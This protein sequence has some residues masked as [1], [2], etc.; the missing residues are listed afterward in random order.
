MAEYDFQ[1]LLKAAKENPS[2]ERL[3]ALGEWLEEFGLDFWNG[4]S[5]DL[6]DGSRLRPVQVPDV[7]DDDGTVLQWRVD[8]WELEP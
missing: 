8:A 3:M 2:E 6:G 4:E 5:Y 1:K 7:I